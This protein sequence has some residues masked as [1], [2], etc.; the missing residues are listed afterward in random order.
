VPDTEPSHAGPADAG[1][2]DAGVPPAR[3]SR[4]GFVA[5]GAVVVGIGV[6]W[7][8]AL[9]QTG[10]SNPDRFPDRA[11]AKQ[12][13]VVCARYGDQIDALPAARTFATVE[14]KSEALRQRADVGDRATDLLRAMVAELGRTAPADDKSRTGVELW[15]KDWTLYL[16]DRDRHVADWRAGNDRQFAETAV[17][18]EKVG[19]GVPVSVRMDTFADVNDMAACEVP[20]DFG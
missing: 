8:L 1:A 20:Q 9:G 19:K 11:W 5:A 17:Q 18:G 6:M 3:R 16:A 12:A 2:S 4:L 14:P 15:L 7:I 13:S 10:R